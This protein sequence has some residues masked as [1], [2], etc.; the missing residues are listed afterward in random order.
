MVPAL[1]GAASSMEITRVAMA[2]TEGDRIALREA[3]QNDD[4]LL[5]PPMRGQKMQLRY[6]AIPKQAYRKHYE[7]VSNTVLWFLQHYLYDPTDGS[8]SAHKIQDAWE[9]GYVVANQPI[10]NALNPEI[11]SHDTI[12]IFMFH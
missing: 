9:N 12:P 8:T 4:G 5:K 10:A 2:M 11:E 1:I 3:Q 7:Q 6:V